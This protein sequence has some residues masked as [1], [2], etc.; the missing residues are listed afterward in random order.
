MDVAVF[1]ALEAA[2]ALENDVNSVLAPLE[3]VGILLAENR[4]LDALEFDVVLKDIALF[5]LRDDALDVVD[6]PAPLGRVVLEEI[7]E[8]LGIDEVIDGNDFEATDFVGP[9][10]SEPADAAEPID[11][12]FD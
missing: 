5:V 12:E 4:D 7:G 9:P 6:V 3:I 8:G 10:E 1:V 11:C 2:R